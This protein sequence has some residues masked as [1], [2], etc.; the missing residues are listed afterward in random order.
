M[1]RLVL[2]SHQPAIGMH[3]PALSMHRPVLS[4]HQPALSMHRL[5]LRAIAS[6]RLKHGV[7]SPISPTSSINRG[8]KSS[9]LINDISRHLRDDASI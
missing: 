6:K 2:R 7:L 4:M 8:S 5:V 1:H 9:D 3:R